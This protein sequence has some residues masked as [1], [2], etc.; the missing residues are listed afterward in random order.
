MAI[1]L[2]LHRT[3]CLFNAENISKTVIQ[4]PGFQVPVTDYRS[5]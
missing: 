1:L 2:K 4:V 5:E 3:P